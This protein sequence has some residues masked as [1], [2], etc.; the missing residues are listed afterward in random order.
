[1]IIAWPAGNARKSHSQF[2]LDP[3]LEPE[4]I[5]IR[6]VLGIVVA[7]RHR[8]VVAIDRIA[9]DLPAENYATDHR[10][11]WIRSPHR[12]RLHPR[13]QQQFVH[14]PPI[15]RLGIAQCISVPHHD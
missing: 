1:M 11:R 2:F 12:Y 14:G 5:A 3:W 4:S 15:A 10:T 6:R 7:P 8:P 9:A 13:L